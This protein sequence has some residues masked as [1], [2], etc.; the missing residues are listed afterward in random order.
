MPRQATKPS[1]G[2]FGSDAASLGTPPGGLDSNTAKTILKP[3]DND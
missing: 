1:R 3:S 2:I